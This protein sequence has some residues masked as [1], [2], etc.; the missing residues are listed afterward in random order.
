MRIEPGYVEIFSAVLKDLGH[1]PS[2]FPLPQPGPVSEDEFCRML[3]SLVALTQKPSLALR[4]GAAM[5]LGT[6]G[7]LGHAIL[8]SRS[9]R[10]AAGLMIQ[11]SPLQGAQ[12]RIHLAFTSNHA[13]L[14][15]DPPFAVQ[16]GSNVRIA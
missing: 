5:H 8:S 3:E 14:T 12:G 15:F 1:D 16:G 13:I 4:L 7:L 9:L 10:Q 11:Y 2:V 6:H